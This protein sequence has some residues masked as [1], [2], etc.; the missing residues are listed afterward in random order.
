MAMQ[1][2]VLAHTFSNDIRI[3]LESARRAEFQ[4]VV[5]DPAV[6]GSIVDSSQTARREIIAL[7]NRFEQPLIAVDL[8]LSNTGFSPKGDLERELDRVSRAM[9]VAR[10]LHGALVLV[11]LGQLPP[12]PDERAPAPKIDPGLLGKL[13]LPDTVAPKSTAAPIPRDE[14]FE[15]SLQTALRELGTRCDRASCRVAFRS[16]LGS[17]ASLYF[18][19]SQVDCP[20]FGVDLDPLLMLADEWPGDEIFSRLGKQLAHVRGRDGLKGTGNRV[21]PTTIGKGVV[22]WREL[23]GQLRDADYRGAITIDAIDLPNRSASAVA[24]LA[25]LRALH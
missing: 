4:G 23:T 12:A 17:F 22:D 15:S 21:S 2:S 25:F 9:D 24:G 11:D 16:S 14:A 13:I 7:L 20:W 5:L 1:I 3:A 10:G 6:F 8:H 19:L 18:A